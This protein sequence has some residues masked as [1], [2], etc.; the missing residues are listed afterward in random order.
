MGYALGAFGTGVF[1]T[2]P[3]VL[4]LYF[5]T[6][7]LKMAPALGATVVLLPKLWALVWDPAVGLWSDRAQ[8]AIGRRRPF[9]LAGS[10]GVPLTFLALFAWPYPLGNAAFPWVAL[11]YFLLTN[12]YSLFAVPFTAVPAEISED[13][14]ERERVAAWRIGCAMIGTLI[15]AG[16]APILVRAG[17][18]G[19]EGY[20]F[21]AVVVSLICCAGMFAAFFATPSATGTRTAQASTLRQVI[22]ILRAERPFRKLAMAYV[23]QLTGVGIVSALTPYWIVQVAGRTEDGVGT[24]LGVM[25]S[26]TII[27]TPLWAL[28]VRRFGARRG[29][30]AAAL[31]FG[32][33]TLGFL[34]V[35]PVPVLPS[36]LLY[37]LIGFPFAGL[38]VGPFALAAHLTHAA[39]EA[40]GGNRAG[41]FTGVWTA[42]EKLGLA[43]GP[44]VA[45]L[46]LA[47]VGFQSGLPVQS[48]EALR[49]LS[50]LLAAAP[51]VFVWASLALV[52]K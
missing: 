46:G 27:S 11:I 51:S 10:V 32:A 3:T 1:A 49:G 52:R 23:L 29:I 38:Q 15:G 16:L 33:A 9:L 34:A 13:A 43:L 20:L 4:L 36:L 30:S 47:V 24:A 22:P 37:A 5:C 48:Q 41:L 50:V 14:A 12:A 2:V 26:V 39:G 18:S 35:P 40:R 42:S 17:G 45:G 21:M 31:L 6:E 8:T 28:V 7:N 19:R 44:G 25:L